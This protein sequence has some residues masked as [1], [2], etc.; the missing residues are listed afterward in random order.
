MADNDN[1]MLLKY[2]KSPEEGHSY[3]EVASQP[4]HTEPTWTQKEINPLY[5]SLPGAEK[6]PSV[7]VR[8]AK[9]TSP[10]GAPAT[11]QRLEGKNNIYGEVGQQE[12]SG[13]KRYKDRGPVPKPQHG[14][15]RASGVVA[16][17]AAVLFVGLALVL[18]IAALVLFVFLFL[19]ILP[20]PSS[21]QVL[22]MPRVAWHALL[23]RAHILDTLIMA[24]NSLIVLSPPSAPGASWHDISQPRT[25]TECLFWRC[26]YS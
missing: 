14:R 18:S 26:V 17:G 15:R 20:L 3:P 24:I 25:G 21:N 1:P 2:Q 12:P 13:K 7:A 16:C 22:C 9:R 23:R 5:E 19:G 4:D 10:A 6:D 11:K 8:A